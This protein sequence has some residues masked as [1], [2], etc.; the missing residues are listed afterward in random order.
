[1]AVSGRPKAVGSSYTDPGSIAFRTVRTVAFLSQ[2][3]PFATQ[4]TRY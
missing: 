2:N 1:M 3:S 4:C